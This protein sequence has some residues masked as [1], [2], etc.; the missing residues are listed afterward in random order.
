MSSRQ[1][2]RVFIGVTLLL[3]TA[4]W[5]ANHFA[6]ALVIIRDQQGVSSLMVNAAF[7]IYAIGMLPCLLAGG[8]LSDRF[9]PR[10]IVLTGGTIAGLGN[11]VMLFAHEGGWL[12]LGR[13][14]VGIGVG[15]VVS[16]GTAWAGLLRGG[17]GVTLAG[18]ILTIGFAVG[19]IATSL[20][21]AS[22]ANIALIF[23]VSVGFSALAVVLG[24][25]LG[26]A[27]R[28][29]ISSEGAGSAPAQPRNLNKALAVSLPMALWVFSCITTSVV[30][31]S[32]RAADHINS[33]ILLPA[34]SS[35][36]AFGAGLLMQYLGRRFA[37]GRKSGAAGALLA[38]AGFALAAFGGDDLTVFQFL[39]AALLL[40][41]AYG[42]CLREGLI[43]INTYVPLSKHGTGIGI[44]YV[45]TYFGFAFPFIFELLDPVV[46]LS[47]PLYFIA[48]MALGSA[49]IRSVQIRRGYLV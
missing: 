19:P 38:A 34:L 25:F 3:F 22:T 24:L 43:G 44:Y 11:L 17:S 18:I 20:I 23:A 2:T 40:G 28:V 5:A 8:V 33:P 46:G 16:A 12:L 39:L 27:P 4:G 30:I 1:S 48:L 32:A 47:A 14:T 35:G 36:L 9:G 10:F 13:F 21:G 42:L 41:C 26:D 6:S 31:L 7:G 45:F 49:V 37:W 29:P 15:L